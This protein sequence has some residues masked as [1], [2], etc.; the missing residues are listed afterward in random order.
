MPE[1]LYS[2]KFMPTVMIAIR[3]VSCGRYAVDGDMGKA[4]YWASSAM[5]VYSITWMGK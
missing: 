2:V 5:L 4:V 3:V 1:F